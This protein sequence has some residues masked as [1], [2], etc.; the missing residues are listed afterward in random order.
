MFFYALRGNLGLR[1][2]ISVFLIW[3]LYF[4]VSVYTGII[5]L[6]ALLMLVAVI[7]TCYGSFV[8]CQHRDDVD[9]GSSFAKEHAFP[10]NR[11]NNSATL[12]MH[13]LSF[14]LFF[15]APALSAPLSYSSPKLQENLAFS[16]VG[17]LLGLTGIVGVLHHFLRKTVDRKTVRTE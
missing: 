3:N 12:Y 16:Y 15:L 14:L 9:F 7:A 4:L 10:S 2:M 11:K 5:W 8:L 1:I 13:L 17:F 6:S